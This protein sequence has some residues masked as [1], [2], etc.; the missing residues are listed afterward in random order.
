MKIAALQ[1]VSGTDVSRNLEIAATLIGEAAAQGAALV[2][3]PEYFCVMGQRDGDKLA[4]AESDGAGPIQDFL[5]AQAQQHRLWL[6]GGTLPIRG[7]AA[8]HARNACCVYAPDGTRAARYDKIHLFR[9]DN[10]RESY[11]EARV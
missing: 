6:V 9:F 1:T 5:A 3:L 11:D 10:G 7:A 2:A 8:D 4:I